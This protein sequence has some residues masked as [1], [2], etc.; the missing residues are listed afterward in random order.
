[1]KSDSIQK[2]SQDNQPG[3]F[4]IKE[5]LEKYYVFRNSMILVEL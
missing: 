5:N 4:F 3:I 2:G 1:M